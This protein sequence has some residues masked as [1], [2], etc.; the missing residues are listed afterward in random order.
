MAEPAKTITL[1]AAVT[2]L[3]ATLV[4]AF[5]LFGQAQAGALRQKI[6][7][8]LNGFRMTISGFPNDRRA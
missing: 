3:N 5:S 8:G 2:H 6:S 4:I 7:A 1:R